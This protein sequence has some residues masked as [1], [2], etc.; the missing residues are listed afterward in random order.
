MRAVLILACFIVSGATAYFIE[1]YVA[2]NVNAL[3][4]MET[5]FTVFAGF[6]VAII[7]IVGDPALI[8]E[9]SWRTA[10]VRRENI[11]AGLIVHMWLFI[12]YL[13]AIALIFVGVVIREIPPRI[14]PN[15]IKIWVN[16]AYL[17]CGLSSFLFTFGL[18]KS[19]FQL[20]IARI[21]AEIAKRRKAA[22]IPD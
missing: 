21:D 2:A 3:L 10:E 9:G 13:L 19:L 17:F 14:I 11:E 16:R 18:A 22:G 8:P 20:Q 4:I 15:I 1:P 5:V 7:A 12:L 6:L